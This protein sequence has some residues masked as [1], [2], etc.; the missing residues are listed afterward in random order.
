MVVI[1]GGACSAQDTYYSIFSYSYFIP[2]VRI[3]DRAISLQQN[4][5]PE[6][7]RER[8]AARDMR[9]VAEND[10]AITTFWQQQG[11]TVL[12]ILREFSGI[13][14]YESE[15]DIYLL[16]YFPTIGSPDPLIIPVGGMKQGSLIEAAPEGNR[17][18]FNLVFQL[19]RRMLAQADQRED[20][21]TLSVA[22]HPLM[23]PG[24][25]RLDNL[26]L[27]LT[28]NT[29]QNILGLDST[30]EAYESAFCRNKFP[31]RG[32]FE[33]YLRDA[34]FL[35]PDQ[36]LADW[37]ASE[38]AN[39]QLVY[40]TRP[41]RR[42]EPAAGD[43]AEQYVEGLPLK[44][45]LGFSVRRSESNQ[46]VVDNIDI[47]R[48]AYACGL[49]T[50]DVIRRVDGRVVRNQK[51]LIENI[52]NGLERGG[53][54]VQIVREERAEEVIIQPIL[55]DPFSE[56]YQL[57]EEYLD[58]FDSLDVDTSLIPTDDF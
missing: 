49:R 41:P 57:E 23:R 51:I 9:W 15:F 14:W 6:L 48:L 12:H 50:G 29:C 8:S 11:D 16:R 27:L 58:D 20:S 17:L 53:S 35:S 37:I 44:G 18:I 24:A 1:M 13:E 7:Y 36:T 2:R 42:V 5:L 10:S 33:N 4:V 54:V 21:V 47:Y 26:A 3:N 22:Y 32:I 45:R 39:S 40:V 19:A 55:F 43:T 25:Y 31:G 52:L 46:L 38:P 30:L 28:F 56:D 34:W